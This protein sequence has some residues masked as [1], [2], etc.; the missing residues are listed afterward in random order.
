MKSYKNKFKELTLNTIKSEADI[1]QSLAKKVETGPICSSFTLTDMLEAAKLETRVAHL[2]F[3]A[4]YFETD[5]FSKISDADFRAWIE[6]NTI[7]DIKRAISGKCSINT[8][9]VD[10][11]ALIALNVLLADI[12]KL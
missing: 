12:E 11:A 2:G 1:R 4:E 8:S 3:S 5:D 7:P 9:I 6:T 10:S